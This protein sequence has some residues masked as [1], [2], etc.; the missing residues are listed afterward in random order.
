M[1]RPRRINHK[2]AAYKHLFEF[3]AQMNCQENSLAAGVRRGRS[4]IA[5]QR[6]ARFWWF[7]IM[8][9]P[10]KQQLN[11]KKLADELLL[12]LACSSCAF[13]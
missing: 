10:S 7:R 11:N 13:K 6:A 4:M 1:V 9:R 3:V 5:L 8:P 2:P 12:L